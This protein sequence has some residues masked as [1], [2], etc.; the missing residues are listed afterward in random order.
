MTS[1]KSFDKGAQAGMK[2]VLNQYKKQCEPDDIDVNACSMLGKDA[3]RR[4]PRGMLR[5][6]AALTLCSP[7][8]TTSTRRSVSRLV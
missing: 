2:Q 8:L 4:L 6:T 3:A 5:Y 1:V 7:R